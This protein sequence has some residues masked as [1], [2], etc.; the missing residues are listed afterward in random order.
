MTMERLSEFREVRQPFTNRLLFRFDA[1]RD[2]I[3]VQYRNVKTLIDL[4]ELR[5]QAETDALAD[6][7]ERVH[8]S[9]H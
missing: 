4:A 7:G 1:A 5:R 8:I 6:D 3:E 2:L 9:T